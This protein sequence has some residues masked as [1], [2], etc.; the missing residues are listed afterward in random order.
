MI[1]A[2]VVELQQDRSIVTAKSTPNSNQKIF[3]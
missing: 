1:I 3:K 2:F